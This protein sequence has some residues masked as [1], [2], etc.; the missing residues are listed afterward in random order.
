MIVLV[1]LMRLVFMRLVIMPVVLG[2]PMKHHRRR[3]IAL[4]DHWLRR[5]ALHDH[6]RWH[7]GFH[8]HRP[9]CVG[10]DNDRWRR[11]VD[12]GRWDA[13]TQEAADNASDDST[14]HR[15]CLIVVI[16]EGAHGQHGKSRA[17]TKSDKALFHFLTP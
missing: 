11:R 6:R 10:L 7:I 15:I 16:R 3:R 12:R 14:D 4:H 17:G 5:I 9:W 1:V 8:D 13:R 2:G